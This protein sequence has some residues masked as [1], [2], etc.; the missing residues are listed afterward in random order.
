MIVIENP[1]G[2]PNAGERAFIAH[3]RGK[4]GVLLVNFMIGGGGPR[5]PGREID[6]IAILPYGIFAVEVKYTSAVGELDSPLNDAWSVGD[7]ESP[8]S[9]SNRSPATQADQAAKILASHLDSKEW[10]KGYITPVVAIH[11]NV[12]ITERVRWVGTVGVSTVEHFDFVAKQA[13]TTRIQARHIGP[14]LMRLGVSK[15]HLPSLE[16][17]IK[18]GFAE[19]VSAKATNAPRPR[20]ASPP[21]ERGRPAPGTTA[22]PAKSQHPWAVRPIGKSR[23]A[24]ATVFGLT[25]ITCVLGAAALVNG[26]LFASLMSPVPGHEYFLYGT[27]PQPKHSTPVIH[28]VG[29]AF[30]VALGAVWALAVWVRARIGMLAPAEV[31]GFLTSVFLTIA[32]APAA[33]ASLGWGGVLIVFIAYVCVWPILAVAIRELWGPLGRSLDRAWNQYEL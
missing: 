17:L 3:Q 1:S 7:I 28:A 21:Q 11:G 2:R 19:E 26:G 20:K 9:S 22:A 29:I 15:N 18:E 12:T 5:K 13:K 25:V 24:I 14:M 33:F 4:Q 30:L 31:A 27:W 23:T 6:A 32:T 10:P 16:R 8:F